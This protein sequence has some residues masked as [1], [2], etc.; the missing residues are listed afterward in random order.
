MQAA[1]QPGQHAR[2]KRSSHTQVTEVMCGSMC[3]V[4]SLFS[5]VESPYVIWWINLW[6]DE[7]ICDVLN[8]LF[9]LSYDESKCDVLNSIM[10][11][12]SPFLY[13]VRIAGGWCARL[14]WLV[15]RR[16]VDSGPVD[17]QLFLFFIFKR[18]V[19]ALFSTNSASLC[20]LLS[21]THSCSLSLA[22]LAPTLY[23][24]H[25]LLKTLAVMEFLNCK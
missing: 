1:S 15:A 10:N 5:C 3:W 24:T 4:S 2:C 14:T 13:W 16:A 18:L 20:L 7:L 22:V 19:T 17:T 21:I 9:S 12:S 8:L 11:Q 6:C 23:I 25:C